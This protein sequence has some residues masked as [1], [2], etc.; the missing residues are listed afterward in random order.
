MLLAKQSIRCGIRAHWPNFD[1][2]QFW[3]LELLSRLIIFLKLAAI[4][5]PHLKNIWDIL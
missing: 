4:H 3:K 5:H 2:Y 1:M